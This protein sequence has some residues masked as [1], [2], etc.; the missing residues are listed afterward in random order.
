[1]RITP[2]IFKKCLIGC[3]VKLRWK[4]REN[5][6]VI[7]NSFR[8]FEKYATDISVS[9][10]HIPGTGSPHVNSKVELVNYTLETIKKIT[11][12]LSS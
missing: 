7:Y 10:H 9:Q 2:E 11:D 1:M 12:T 8:F 4:S 3:G 6:V 5:L